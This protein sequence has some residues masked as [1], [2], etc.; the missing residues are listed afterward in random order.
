MQAPLLPSP[1]HT[2]E[3]SCIHVDVGEELEVER[4]LQ[5]SL[6]APA[7]L[8]DMEIPFCCFFFFRQLSRKLSLLIC[9]FEGM[10]RGG[11][12]DV[13]GQLTLPNI[14]CF[15]SH[16]AVKRERVLD[17]QGDKSQTSAGRVRAGQGPKPGMR[18]PKQGLSPR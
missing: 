10:R 4:Q 6:H 12:V 1:L 11:S 15:I 9:S 2:G 13:Q 5:A 16:V 8:P 18:T 14:I 17:E 3:Q 7:S